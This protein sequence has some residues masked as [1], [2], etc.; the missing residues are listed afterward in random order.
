[1]GPQLVDYMTL[2]QNTHLNLKIAE[3]DL[4]Y[5]RIGHYRH[6][7]LDVIQVLMEDLCGRNLGER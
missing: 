6:Y 2:L 1:M 5:R 7:Q 4:G 3:R